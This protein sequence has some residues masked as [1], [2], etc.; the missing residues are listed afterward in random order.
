VGA[1]ETVLHRAFALRWPIR[2]QKLDKGKQQEAVS[3]ES[4][5]SSAVA[6]PSG[7][8]AGE[9]K[10]GAQPTDPAHGLAAPVDEWIITKGSSYRIRPT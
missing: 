9:P 2:R 7:S 10:F 5:A 6:M 4:L 8:N 1:A 3:V